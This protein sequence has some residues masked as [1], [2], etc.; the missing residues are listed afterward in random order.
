MEL[1]SKTFSVDAI[2][3]LSGKVIIVTGLV[4]IM[5][6]IVDT[7]LLNCPFG[8]GATGIG[9][10]AALQL[11]YRNAQVYIASRSRT[12]FD[13]LVNEARDLLS[14][15][16]G[17][18]ISGHLQFLQLD[19]SDMASCVLAAKQF[20]AREKRLDVVVANAALSVIVRSLQRLL[21]FHIF[22]GGFS[23]TMLS[24]LAVHTFEGWN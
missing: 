15:K 8:R 14:L 13:E 7:L 5:Y 4:L 18:E 21:L 3:D 16:G 6:C 11:L 19:L 23:L 17:P 10:E 1:Y 20:L 9:K 24:V 2:P 22:L 12:K